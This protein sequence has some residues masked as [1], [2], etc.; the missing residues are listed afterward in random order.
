[1]L[2]QGSQTRGPR[3]I[4]VLLAFVSKFFLFLSKIQPYVE[5]KN[6]LQIFAVRGNI[7][8]PNAICK[9]FFFETLEFETPVLTFPRLIVYGN[10]GKPH[11]RLNGENL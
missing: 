2:E 11:K 9:L 7:Y 6:I 8:Q 5:L 4:L 10:Q 1:V 3:N